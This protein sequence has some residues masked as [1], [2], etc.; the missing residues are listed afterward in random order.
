MQVIKVRNSRDRIKR[1][2]SLIQGAGDHLFAVSFIT[3]RDGKKRK[4]VCRGGVRKPQYAG[5]PHGKG[6]YD[7]KKYNL[8]TLFSMNDLRYNKRDKLN[9]RGQWK[10]IPL[11]GI[12]R[13]KTEGEIYKIVE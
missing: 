12:M 8:V 5:I 3:R 7:P 6:Q 11:D 1:V 13:I 10:S 2:R 4:M 9:G